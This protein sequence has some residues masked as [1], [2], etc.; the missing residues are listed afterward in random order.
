MSRIIISSPSDNVIGQVTMEVKDIPIHIAPSKID[1]NSP[2]M[3]NYQGEQLFFIEAPY[4]SLI[5]DGIERG[6]KNLRRVMTVAKMEKNIASGGKS[7]KINPAYG[8]SPSEVES[9]TFKMKSGDVITMYRQDNQFRFY[10]NK[11]VTKVLGVLENLGTA[12]DFVNILTFGM[13]S[14][15]KKD[16]LPIPGPLG[17]LNLAVK[18]YFD[19]LDEMISDAE[20]RQLDL[21]KKQGLAAVEKLIKNSLYRQLKYNIDY[22][23]TDSLKEI[24]TGKIKTQ[25]DLI[26][27]IYSSFPKDSA[28]LYRPLE[29]YKG[30]VLIIETLFFNII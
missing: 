4:D 5:I 28:I 8:V 14:G 25:S 7:H 2:E 15:D 9:F 12:V 17:T 27:L 30:I 19:D 22:L 29:T 6:A 1:Y 3:Y 16:L 26:N 21:A 18:R 10:S 20:M 23:S 24:L 11:G 13:N